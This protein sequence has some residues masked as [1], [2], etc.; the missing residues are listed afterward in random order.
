MPMSDLSKVHVLINERMQLL[1]VVL[2]GG[3]IHDSEPVFDLF[4]DVELVGK[5]LLADKAYSSESIRNYLE[6]LQSSVFFNAL[7][8]I[9]TS[10]LVM[11]NVCFLNFVLLASAAIHF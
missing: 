1:K 10:L 8:I 2:I 9:A 5:T 7:R 6:K 11:T 3:Q 4:D